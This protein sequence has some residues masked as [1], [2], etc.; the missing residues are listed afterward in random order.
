MNS[1]EMYT[2]INKGVPCYSIIELDVNTII[3][4]CAFDKQRLQEEMSLIKEL[5]RSY[6]IEKMEFVKAKEYF[7]DKFR[8][9]TSFKNAESNI[10]ISPIPY[11]EKLKR[12]LNVTDES[13]D[14]NDESLYQKLKDRV[15]ELSKI[16]TPEELKI[17]FPLIYEDYL[18]AIDSYPKIKRYEMLHRHD[19]DEDVK[20][21]ISRQ[22]RMFRLHGLHTLFDR[23]IKKQSTMYRNF[24]VRRQFIEGYANRHPLDFSMFTGLD[25]AKFE[26]YLADKYLTRAIESTDDKEKQECVF[27]LATYIRETKVSATTIKNDEGKQISFDYIVRRYKR[28]LQQNHSIRPIDEPRENFKNYNVR[29]VIN[30]VNKYFFTDVNWQIVPPGKEEELDREVIESL[31]RAY[32]YL[33]PEERET[34]ILERYCIYERK[35]RYFEN[36]G[37]AHKIYGINTFAGYIAYI[38]PNGEILMEKYFDDQANCRPTQ[39][40]AIYNVKVADFERL[41]RLAKPVLMKE[42]TCARIIHRGEWEEKAD[43]IVNR[44]ATKETEESVKKLILELQTKRTK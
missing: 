9:M 42:P 15:A 35:K 43:I 27:Y 30:H 1:Q 5:Y 26:L 39:G 20:S 17:K 36:S 19:E 7:L 6:F 14:F 29:H 23:F 3:N 16:T 2:A 18:L 13:V 4:E 32:N 25:K 40:E 24:A 33:S 10:Y 31:N 34:K 11:I 8:I 41:S 21:N 37:Y 22:Y 28:F 44:P 38:Y 12:I